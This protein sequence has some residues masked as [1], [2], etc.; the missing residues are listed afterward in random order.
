MGRK[1]ESLLIHGSILRSFIRDKMKI[2]SFAEAVGATRQT[3]HAWTQSGRISPRGL[4]DTVRVLGLSA[5]DVRLLN[6][7]DESAIEKRL[8]RL[9]ECET[10][11][12]DIRKIL[13]SVL[14]DSR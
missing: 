4:S 3:V 5:E 13:S 7:V 11:L 1:R 12:A 2:E 10:A 9:R 14:G 8:N 6:R